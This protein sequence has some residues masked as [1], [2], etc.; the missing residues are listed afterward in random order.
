MCS[1]RS[2]SALSR[3]ACSVY[4]VYAYVPETGLA[5]HAEGAD[6]VIGTVAA[7]HKAEAGIVEGLHAH[8]YAVHTQLPEAAEIVLSPVEYV[9]R[10]DLKGE[11]QGRGAAESQGAEPLHNAPQDRKRKHAGRASSYI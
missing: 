9:V 11:L 6:G 2:S 3:L 7:V 1:G 8:T 10:I 5:Q 4:K